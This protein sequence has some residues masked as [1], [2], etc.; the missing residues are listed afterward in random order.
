MLSRIYLEI[1]NICNRSCA[2]CPGTKRPARMLT[3][4]ELE[5]LT[6]QEEQED[7]E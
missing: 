3:P 1:T 5:E 6:R 4:E 2:F 7:G